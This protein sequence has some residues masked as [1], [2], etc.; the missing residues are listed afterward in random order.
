M[1]GLLKRWFV[2][3][4]LILLA[5][6]ASACAAPAAAPTQV[7]VTSAPVIQT[8]QVPQTVIVQGTPQVIT[9]TPGASSSSASASSS[10]AGTPAPTLP[11]PPQVKNPDTL[12]EANISEP[13][14]LDP[15]W[16]YE[17]A[18]GQII[19]QVYQPLVF[20]NK[21]A[22]DKYVGVLA[23]DWKTSADGMTWTFT[24]RKGV[25]F[26]NGDPMNPSDVAYSYLRGFIQGYSNSAQWIMLQPFF[27]PTV[28]GT[29]LDP[30]V[31][32]G[33]KTG[34]DVVDTMF[35]GD[36]VAACQAAQKLIVADNN[37][38]TV[39]MTLKQPWAPFLASIANAW[40][41]VIDQK[42]AMAQGDWD[43]NCAN[44][45]KFNNPDAAKSPLYE[46]MMG[47]GPFVLAK[48]DHGNSITLDANPNYWQKD[49]LWQGGP[50][51]APV[52][53]H[54]VIRYVSEWGTRY[55]M[56]TTG[57]ADLFYVPNNF[58]AQ[59]DPLVRDECDALD[60]NCKTVNPKGFLRVSK[61]LP[62]LAQGD[63]FMNQQVNTTGGNTYIGSGKLDGNGI[64][65]NFFS[66]IHIRKAFVACF[67]SAT[68]IK[69]A[70]QG[71][72]VQP[73]GPINPGELGYDK[74]AA[75]QQFSLDTCKSEFDAA[76]K[77]PGFTDLTNKG[78][79]VVITYNAG[80]AIRQSAAQ[81]LA[82]G[83]KKVNPKF[84][85]SVLAQPFA[86]ELNDQQ[87]GRLP[88]FVIG[89]L[90]DYHDPNDWA[91]PYL[92]SGGTYSGTQHFD[93]TLQKQL[94]GL[95]NQALTE[96]DTTKRGA[97]YAQLNKLAIDNALD[98]F[99]Y[100]Q[101]N[102]HYEQLWVNGWYY[103]PI[104]SGAPVS[105]FYYA[106]GKGGAK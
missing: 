51:G 94:D 102:R 58:Y 47:T 20:Y 52:L 61:N 1:K 70:L 59:V 85:L 33:D 27:G 36:F 26:S 97:L 32:P 81:I 9:A 34:D 57:D 99:A 38:G 74:N 17:T 88:L 35:N 95:I 6:I 12:V 79:Y 73:N 49:P 63:I 15:A 41:S 3:G 86:V 56:A 62:G 8:V 16:D 105:G 29:W 40:G 22:V 42:Y 18:G 90:E 37:A 66:D 67:D 106:Y 65:A 28:T 45:Q 46:K 91:G 77:D 5:V 11:P 89:W 13:Q 64:P 80:N 24:I 48:W 23:T 19:Q 87:A 104:L 54:V 68:F 30:N 100:T 39:T 31:K 101:T 10:A 21:D 50:S 43:G 72:A 84:N 83:L 44:A 25:T 75:A 82:D 92:S 7:P 78:F 71:E 76:A 2:P 69:Q 60:G 55:A 93:P 53:K 98:I 103:N 96:T 14:S 4:V